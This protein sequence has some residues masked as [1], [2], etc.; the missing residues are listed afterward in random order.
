MSEEIRHFSAV[1]DEIRDRISPRG[2]QA[3]SSL[4]VPPAFDPR[5]KIERKL[6]AANPK[7]LYA[8]PSNCILHFLTPEHDIVP[9]FTTFIGLSLCADCS[10]RVA[11]AVIDEGLSARELAELAMTGSWV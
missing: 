4:P 9:S 5:G 10:L 11:A 7:L 1:S 3:Q 8:E 2:V 6:P